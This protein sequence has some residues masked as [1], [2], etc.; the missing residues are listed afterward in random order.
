VAHVSHVLLHRALAA[1][2]AVARIAFEVRGIVTC[3]IHMLLA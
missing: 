1:E 2:I 3:G